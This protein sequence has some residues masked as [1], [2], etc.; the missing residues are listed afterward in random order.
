MT[1][2]DYH[3]ERQKRAA[4]E[5]IASIRDQIDGDEEM[6][7]DAIEGETGLFEAIDATLDAILIDQS[8]VDAL[9]VAQDKMKTRQDRF[10]RRIE[11]RRQSLL[12]AMEIAELKKIE[13]ATGTL[14]RRDAKQK[15]IITNEQDIPTQFW[16]RADPRINKTDLN[17]AVLARRDEREDA[18]NAARDIEDDQERGMAIEQIETTLPEIAGAVIDNGGETI[19][20]RFK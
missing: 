4:K 2:V 7:A 20:I 14:S 9:K 8:H 16:Q 1:E 19:S 17:K 5:L 10:L 18:F 15:V 13:R 3:L 12:I 6:L 11:T